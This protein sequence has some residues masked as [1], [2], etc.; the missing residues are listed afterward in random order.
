[1]RWDD[2][3]H[4]RRSSRRR[5]AG[6]DWHWQHPLEY[7]STLALGM[8]SKGAGHLTGG[9]GSSSSAEPQ[10]K[11]ERLGG[12]RA[13]GLGALPSFACFPHHH[14]HPQ[15]PPRSVVL[16]E[17]Y[18]GCAQY[19]MMSGPHPI[20]SLPPSLRPT[21]LIPLPPQQALSI[22][23]EPLSYYFPA[24]PTSQQK[25]WLSSSETKRISTIRRN[26]T[27]CSLPLPR[28]TGSQEL[29]LPSAQR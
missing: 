3:K 22:P 23:L 14:H 1:M 29:E 28:E 19:A 5:Q 9:E 2:P 17:G 20:F 6:V 10:Q 7:K 26:L 8:V 24:L 11:T 25:L 27:H 21:V 15:P 12:T 13:R 16:R 18:D 4:R